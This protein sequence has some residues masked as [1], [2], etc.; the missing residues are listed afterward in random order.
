[1]TSTSDPLYVLRD[2]VKEGKLPKLEGSRVIVADLSYEVTAET[3]Y[4]MTPSQ[5]RRPEGK[6]S[7]R[8]QFVVLSS[9]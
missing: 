4:K 2:W 3:A 5:G 1:M 7:K 8:T 6:E 9:K